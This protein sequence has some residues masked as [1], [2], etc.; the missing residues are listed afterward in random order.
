[1][2]LPLKWEFPGGKIKPGE[3]PEDCLRRE[4]VEELNVKVS[5]KG[6]LPSATYDY[7][8]LKVTL[9]PFICSIEAGKLHANEHAALLWLSLDELPSLDWAEADLSLIV[10]YCRQRNSVQP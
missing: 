10:D 9:Y 8:D 1:M 3:S 2:S 6:V 7:P 4:L 5:V